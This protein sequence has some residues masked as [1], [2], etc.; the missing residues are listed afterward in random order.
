MSSRRQLMTR[1]PEH[2]M[3]YKVAVVGATGAVGREI[4]KLLGERDFPVATMTALGAPNTTG[5]E[6]SFGDKIVLK[7]QNL[8]KFD[9]S[10]CQIAF[11]CMGPAIS[12]AH[13]GRAAA[14][15]CLV[16]DCTGHFRM[17]P[18]V[19]L[20]VPEVNPEA[21][22]RVRRRIIAS[23]GSATTQMVVALKPLHDRFTVK[24]V[25][26]STYQAVSGAGK[27]GMDEL[28][29]QSRRS[30]V[31]DQIVP[32]EFSK[33]IAFNCI[34]QVEKFLDDGS[35]DEESRMGLETRKILSPD[36]KVTATCVTVP[37]FIGHGM[38]VNVELE[39]PVT[40]SDARAAFRNAPGLT[41]L[42]TREDGGYATQIECQG[43]DAVF[44]GRI[45]KDTTVEHGL[46]FWCVADNLRKGSA[47]NAVQIAELAAARNLL[48][49]DVGRV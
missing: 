44:V 14:T 26:A 40:V 19:P 12:A 42:D 15:G 39:K 21:I 32:Q 25:V 30:L 24:R 43:E 31:H 11:F 49:K 5:S 3:A 45:R 27:N 8:E 48:A 7:V 10:D 16:I 37:V 36:V 6:L 1:E 18:S 20:I 41:V 23:P 9:F 29:L 2:I 13:A 28:F 4:L 33:Q 46:A 22:T 47:L 34:P 38:S 35:T 17:D